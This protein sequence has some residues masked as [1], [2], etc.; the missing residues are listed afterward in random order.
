VSRYAGAL[1]AVDRIL[2]RGGDADEVLRAVVDAL[3]TR[4]I[5]Y[6]A[7]RFVEGDRL[8]EGPSAGEP[9]PALSVPIV[10]KGDRVGEL[11]VA[12]DD[13]EFAKRVATLISAHVLVG[14]DTG[15]QAWNP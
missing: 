8:V 5:A 2:N 3:H 11:E 15:G 12:T 10:Y 6:V 1:D 14:W 7:L 4:G 13:E 9:A